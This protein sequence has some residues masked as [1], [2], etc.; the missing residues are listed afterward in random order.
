ML[1]PIKIKQK[2]IKN[3]TPK[4]S[5]YIDH[6]GTLIIP[7]GA[8]P[9]YHYWNGGQPILETLLELRATEDVWRKHTEDPYPGNAA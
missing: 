3:M 9:K 8:D 6:T 7:C 2:E 5:P 4:D 1:L